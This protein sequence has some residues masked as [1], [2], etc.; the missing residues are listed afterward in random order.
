MKVNGV[1]NY[2]VFDNNEY[3]VSLFIIISCFHDEKHNS[4]VCQSY[5]RIST[6]NINSDKVKNKLRQI[7]FR[8]N[9]HSSPI[10]FDKS[11]AK[12]FDDHFKVESRN[13]GSL[14]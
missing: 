3:E 14:D 10:Y 12:H 5:S 1:E 11:F 4:L 13:E 2:A 6:F 7:K 8:M 9:D